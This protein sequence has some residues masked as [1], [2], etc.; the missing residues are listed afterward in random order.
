MNAKTHI[1]DVDQESFQAAVLDNSNSFPVL[2][3]F[4]AAWCGPCRALAPVLEKLAEEYSG[5]FLLA[6]V[7]SDEQQELATSY[8]IRSLPTVKVFKNGAVVDEFLGV[9]PESAIR[10][11]LERHVERESDRLRERA[12]EALQQNETDRAAS[13][14]KQALADDPDNHRIH[15]D[16]AQV[17]MQQANYGEAEDVLKQLPSDKRDTANVKHMLAQ[18]G[19]ARIA[20]DAPLPDRLLALISDN[21][22]DSEARYQ[23]SAHRVLAEDFEGAMEQLLEIM[24]YDR[25][26]RDDAGRKG[27]LSVFEL[28]DGA[29]PLVSRYRTLMSSA[30]H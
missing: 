29:G 14:L 24:R 27:L 1:I 9:Q 18:L 23:L 5:K 10:A 26:F 17:L 6:K 25:K 8:G 3:D 13:L 12:R 19:F 7:N 20:A 11:L 28:L 16:L 21:P 2:V 4:W 30:L 15:P 22:A